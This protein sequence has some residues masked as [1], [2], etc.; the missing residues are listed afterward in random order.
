MSPL[1]ASFF[2]L[3]AQGRRDVHFRLVALA[4]QEWESFCQK[5]G[6]IHYRDSVVGM[7]H[8]LDLKLP[9][10]AIASLHSNQHIAHI[11]QRYLE[12]IV[13]M[14]DDDLE[15]VIPSSM[16]FAY[17]GIYNLFNKYSDPSANI[18]DWLIVNQCLSALPQPEWDSTLG[19]AIAEVQK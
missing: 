4:L 16:Q 5:A 15:S 7:K 6:S 12:P 19:R 3:S 17:Y 18:E 9:R 8:D 10:D 2:A 11:R 14:Q 13:A 1:A